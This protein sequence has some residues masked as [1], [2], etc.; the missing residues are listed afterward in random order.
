M[1]VFLAGDGYGRRLANIFDD[2]SNSRR[3]V[4]QFSK[5]NGRFQ[6][7]QSRPVINFR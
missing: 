3:V 1:G 5:R 4:D 6:H 2:F 7:C